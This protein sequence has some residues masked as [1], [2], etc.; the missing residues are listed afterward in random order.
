MNESLQNM[1]KIIKNQSNEKIVNTNTSRIQQIVRIPK[2]FEIINMWQ[3]AYQNI[4]EFP[5]YGFKTNSV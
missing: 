1:N 4:I 2:P 3:L 5:L